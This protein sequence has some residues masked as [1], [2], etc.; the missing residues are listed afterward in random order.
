MP[1]GSK[2]FMQGIEKPT[3]DPLELEIAKVFDRFRIKYSR[4]ERQ[5]FE[6]STLDFF[7]PDYELSVEVKAWSSERLHKQLRNSGKEKEGILV[8]IGLESVK[9]FAQILSDLRGKETFEPANPAWRE[10]GGE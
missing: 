8:F 4:P 7:L 10:R 6:A 1:R 2:R 5:P 9:K 3:S